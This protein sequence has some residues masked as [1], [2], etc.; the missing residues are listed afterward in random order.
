[1][2]PKYFWDRKA[3]S[4]V[5][6][7]PTVSGEMFKGSARHALASASAIHLSHIKRREPTNSTSL[8]S[9]RNNPAWT[10]LLVI[11]QS[12]IRQ[13]LP[14]LIALVKKSKLVTKLLPA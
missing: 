11:F 6:R 2:F 1:M 14:A 5:T 7:I 8:L 9:G 4:G 12:Y 13:D 3:A 10:Y